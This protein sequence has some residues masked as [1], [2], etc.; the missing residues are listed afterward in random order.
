MPVSSVTRTRP[1]TPAQ[2]T[3][4][5]T[6]VLLRAGDNGKS[7]SIESVWPTGSTPSSLLLAV[8]QLALVAGKPV[9]REVQPAQQTNPETIVASPLDTGEKSGSQSAL[10]IIEPRRRHANSKTPLA[11]QTENP[12]PG[13]FDQE[14]LAAHAIRLV[15]KLNQHS[16]FSGACLALVNEISQLTGATRVC[17]GMIR[18]GLVSIRT[19]SGSPSP[20]SQ[21]ALQRDLAM[22]MG[23]AIDQACTIVYPGTQRRSGVVTLNHGRFTIRHASPSLCTVPLPVADESGR[24]LIGALSLEFGDTRAPD[25]QVVRFVE[26]IASLL[27]PGLDA[28]RQLS[29]PI[30]GRVATALSATHRKP[31]GNTPPRRRLFTL[32]AGGL[33]A[34]A[35][36]TPLPDSVVADARIE[37]ARQRVLSAPVD[38]FVGTVHFKPGDR[39]AAGD[40]MVSLDDREL[41]LER[42]KWLSQVQQYE[43][44]YSKA[45]ASGEQAP[46]AIERARLAQARAQLEATREQL[47]RM[48]LRAPFDAIVLDGDLTQASGAPVQRGQTLMRLAP[49]GEHRVIIAID[50]RDV[51]RVQ[52]G[53]SARLVLAAHSTSKLD[54]TVDS[55]NPVARLSD[56]NNY[57]DASAR[58]DQPTPLAQPGLVGVARI[59]AGSRSLLSRA[60]TRLQQWL[61][62]AIWRWQP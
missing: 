48:T 28:R 16:D 57:F 11:G 52:V 47:A 50:E 59:A 25:P 5:A 26:H 4:R 58:L 19:M 49:A 2:G 44:Q 38:G 55:I 17:V 7:P 46:I 30:T 51:G 24:A 62:M 27:A 20:G 18:D 23:E 33:V 15:A 35:L 40:V 42:D 29:A 22:A 21:T 32:L 60:T 45:L 6:A 37:G 34:A 56:G 54:L 3:C 53:S 10:A 31:L 41:S 14:N 1:S 9:R 12:R 43:R 13:T 8:A 61:R 39:V 36:F